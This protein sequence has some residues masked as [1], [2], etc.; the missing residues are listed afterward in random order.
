[1]K[2]SIK[3]VKIRNIETDN[4]TFSLISCTEKD[5]SHYN[6]KID[7]RGTKFSKDGHSD[8]ISFA[9]RKKNI[10]FHDSKKQSAVEPIDGF[11]PITGETEEQTI[12]RIK[13]RFDVLAELTEAAASGIC[14]SI[15]ASGPAGVGKSYIVEDKLRACS[16]FQ[17]SEDG[18]DPYEIICG[19]EVSP[20]GLYQVLYR[21]AAKGR[22]LVMDD[23]DSILC[24]P[25]TLS[26][27]KS[28]LNTSGKRMCHY[29]TESRILDSLGIPTKFEFQGSVIFITNINFNNCRSQKLAPH[30]E[31][32]QSRSLYLDLAIH[33]LRERYLR[34]KSIL[35]DSIMLDDYS[36]SDEQIENLLSYIKSRVHR[37]RT[38]DLRTV[39]KAADLMRAKPNSWERL[40]DI[41]LLR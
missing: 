8:I 18:K 33:G 24:Q 32:L 9:V 13:E 26:L 12:T 27:L 30:L 41:T 2:V 38:F 15:I 11:N 28:A 29:V 40:C 31:A 23:S 14:K 17:D 34:I 37:F 39:I 19:A 5:E 6:L 7:I 21:N 35:L 16:F 10:T 36:F 1:M 3:G 20:I 25:E 4:D 22:V